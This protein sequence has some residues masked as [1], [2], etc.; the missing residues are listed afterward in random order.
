M[1]FTQTLL[2]LALVATAGISQAAYNPANLQTIAITPGQT[3]IGSFTFSYD[4]DHIASVFLNTTA[5]Q[6]TSWWG[7]FRADG[8][9]SEQTFRSDLSNGGNVQGFSL[10]LYMGDQKYWYAFGIT[11]SND[12]QGTL[13]L[14]VAPV[15]EPETWALMGIGLTG[16]LLARRKKSAGKK[17]VVAQQ[18]A[19]LI[20]A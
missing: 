3:A 9:T 14:E 13:A 5:G 11:A 1:R 2:A 7:A 6:V 4:N 8:S 15:P 20:A 17:A 12:W 18:T 10:P 16:A 19:G